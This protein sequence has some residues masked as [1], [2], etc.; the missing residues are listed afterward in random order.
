MG[1]T[2]QPPMAHHQFQELVSS[3]LNLRQLSK[4]SIQEGGDKYVVRQFLVRI[5]RPI[6]SG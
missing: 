5:L 1:G 3:L 2:G 4:N 6:L